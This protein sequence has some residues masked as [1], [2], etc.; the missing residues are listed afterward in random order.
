MFGKTDAVPLASTKFCTVIDKDT[1]ERVE[2]IYEI[3]ETLTAPIKKGDVVGRII[4]KSDGLQI[5]FSEVISD[6]DVEKISI[7]D[8][9]VRILERI[10]F[11]Y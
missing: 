11:S 6:A 3:P 2:K 9:F 1:L 8:L 4:Y 10:I 5:G 7:F